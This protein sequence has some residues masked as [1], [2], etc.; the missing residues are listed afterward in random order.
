[1]TGIS[2]H[3]ANRFLYREN[4]QPKD[5]YDEAL[6]VLNPTGGTLSVNDRVLDK[7]YSYSVALVGYFWFGKH[8]RLIKGINLIP[9]ILHRHVRVTHAG[10][11]QDI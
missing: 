1:M 10:K 7:P 9:L 6:E 5:M 8:H 3:S 2:H 4:Y 11:L